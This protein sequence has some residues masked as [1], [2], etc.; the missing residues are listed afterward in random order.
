MKIRDIFENPESRL[1]KSIAKLNKELGLTVKVEVD[2]PTVWAQLQSNFP[3]VATFVPSITDL[4]VTLIESVGIQCEDEHWSDDLLASLA[5]EQM[6]TLILS[7][8]VGDESLIPKSSWLSNPARILLTVP[9]MGAVQLNSIS[10]GT[11]ARGLADIFNPSATA[12]ALESSK[13]AEWADLGVD[14][15]SATNNVMD[16][17]PT[18]DDLPR[19][20]VL[21][22]QSTPYWCTI[23]HQRDTTYE[24]N[25]THEGTLELVAT[26]LEAYAI[27][28]KNSHGPLMKVTRNAACFGEE[29]NYDSLTVEPFRQTTSWV[30][31]NPLLMLSLLQG[32][33]G[34]SFVHTDGLTWVLKRD[35]PFRS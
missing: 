15:P 11:L 25:F 5:D 3:D 10:A 8:K 19:P 31:P 30:K 13:D 34:Y 1:Q 14:T 22:A 4:G 12:E 17:L 28:N 24:A 23:F 35:R 21:L 6:K 16:V 2:W 29:T 33:L 9:T 32:K 27:P 26:Y 7:M 20:D 18:V